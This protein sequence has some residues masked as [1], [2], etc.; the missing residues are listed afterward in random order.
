[1]QNYK[2]KQSDREHLFG[3]FN[4]TVY[5]IQQREGLNNLILEKKI[6]AVTEELQ[7]KNTQLTEV[8]KAAHVDGR[9]I[10]ALAQSIEEI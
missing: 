9:A 2:Y 5:S 3:I 1:M 6:G 8:L 4:N 7:V 10:G